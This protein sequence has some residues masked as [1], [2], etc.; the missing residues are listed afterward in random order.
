[1][2]KM[3]YIIAGI[4]LVVVLAIAGA[5]VYYHGDLA[6]KGPLAVVQPAD[7]AVGETKVALTALQAFSIADGATGV[8]SWKAGAKNVSVAQ[9]STD[10]LA[11][12]MSGTWT[13]T[14]AS[15]SE[16]AA[17]HVENGVMCGM[18]VTKM[19]ERLYP[20]QNTPIS[21]LID[22]T[23]ASDIAGQAMAKADVSSTGPASATLAFKASGAPIWDFNY[24]IDGGSYIVRIDA[25]GGSVTESAT[26]RR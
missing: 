12:G 2:V 14:Y 5:V 20:V 23:R 7:N 17:A 8:K 21:G 26:Q 4:V 9:V 11:G 6:P 25:Q 18:T 24:P 3:A 19:P 16:E 10:F 13:I 1:M 15:D 22:S